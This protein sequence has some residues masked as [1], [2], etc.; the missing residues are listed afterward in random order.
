MM[1]RFN[2]KAGKITA[3]E[4]KS[5]ID[6]NGSFTLSAPRGYLKKELYSE[7]CFAYLRSNYALYLYYEEAV[8]PRGTKIFIIVKKK[9]EDKMENVVFPPS[10]C[11]ELS[12]DGPQ[13][14]MVKKCIKINGFCN[15]EHRLV[16]FLEKNSK[17]LEDKVPGLWNKMLRI[18]IQE[19]GTALVREV[20]LI[21]DD[22]RRITELEIPIPDYL[23]LSNADVI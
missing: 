11:F 1:L 8:Y 22:L 23:F 20:N 10:F 3:E 16:K 13:Y 18:L 17:I 15:K 6:E 2:T 9:N 7:L 14:D 19:D 12:E 5:K 4:L 21:L